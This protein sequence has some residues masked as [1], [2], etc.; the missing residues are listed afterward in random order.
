MEPGGAPGGL[1]EKKRAAPTPTARAEEPPRLYL[2]LAVALLALVV[3]VAAGTL[4]TDPPPAP[5]AV[6]AAPPPGPAGAPS[7]EPAPAPERWERLHRRLEAEEARSQRLEAELQALREEL[8]RLATTLAPPAAGPAQPPPGGPEE[9]PETAREGAGSTP[10]ALPELSVDAL[11]AAGVP[12]GEAQLIRRTA[13]GI[14]RERLFLE[15]RASREGWLG[16]SRYAAE[17]DE[18]N[19]VVDAVRDELGDAAYE[20]LLYTTGRANRVRVQSVIGETP[21]AAAG[22]LPGDRIVR[23]AGER[24]F[25]GRGLRAATREGEPG[26]LVPVEVLREGEPVLLYLPRGPMGIRMDVTRELP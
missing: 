6:A 1:R 9:T 20:R 4:A 26:A 3:G 15:D 13:D 19:A 2:H 22:I 5:G 11:V 8:G 18:I 10:T 7:A 21:A 25:D 14:A 17:L 12:A 24:V 23:Y 16:T